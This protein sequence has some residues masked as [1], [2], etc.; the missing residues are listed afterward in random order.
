MGK[1]ILAYSR[2]DTQGRLQI[3]QFLC[4]ESKLLYSP[5]LTLAAYI[6][7]DHPGAIAIIAVRPENTSVGDTPIEVLAVCRS[8]EK[9]RVNIPFNLRKAIGLN[10][11][12]Q[13]E[14]LPPSSI[15]VAPRE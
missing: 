8:D 3:P 10:G 5:H 1:V 4:D 15:L 7:S 11:D 13:L 14:Y 9:G 12:V 6:D 2:I